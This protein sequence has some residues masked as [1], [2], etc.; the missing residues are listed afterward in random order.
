[1]TPMRTHVSLLALAILGSAAGYGHEGPLLP[2]T[3]P[4]GKYLVLVC[5]LNAQNTAAECS[6][7][8]PV[9]KLPCPPH[10]IGEQSS[11]CPLPPE[12]IRQTITFKQVAPP[13]S[14]TSTQPSYPLSVG[15]DFYVSATASSGLP[16]SITPIAGAV[17]IVP[18]APSAI[19]WPPGTSEYRVNGPGTVILKAE[20]NGAAGYDAAQPV[21]L[22]FGVGPSSSDATCNGLF[23]SGSAQAVAQ[24]NASAVVGL[25]GSPVPFELVAPDTRTILVYTTR[26]P[27]K[28]EEK[29]I[30]D[31][32]PQQINL[33]LSRSAQTLGLAA[34]PFNVELKIP[35]AAALGDPGSRISALNYSALTVQDESRDTVRITATAQPDCT[36]WT[37]FLTD[38][39][40]LAW[41]MS[42]ES[43]V[44]R[45]FYTAQIGASA[46][47][48][49]FGGTA[50]PASGS[51]ASTATAG[52]GSSASGG[53]SG[54]GTTGSTTP[55]ASG[56]SAASGSTGSSTSGSGGSASSSTATIAINQPPGSM[57]EVR[58]DTTPCVIAGLTLSNSSACATAPASSAG[59]SASS[60]STATASTSGPGTPA[61]PPVIAPL[62]SDLALFS[63]ANPGDDEPITEKKR[64]IAQLDLPR[65]EM[66]INAWV[67]QNS[68]TS[69][70]AI[71][72]FSGAIRDLVGQHNDS[73]DIM[74]LQAWRKVR[75]NIAKG[76]YFDEPFYHYVVDR[77]VGD[78][79]TEDASGTT[80]GPPSAQSAA[81][82]FLTTGTGKL[83]LP[84]GY[85]R[86]DFGICP[87]KQYCLGYATM[88]QPMKPRI[89]DTLLALIA[90]KDTL[91]AAEQAIDAAEG[92]P[93][94]TYIANRGFCENLS[95]D[96]RDH[97][98]KIWNELDLEK[99]DRSCESDACTWSASVGRPNSS[100]ARVRPTVPLFLRPARD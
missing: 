14:P 70:E 76:N 61:P 74:Q 11:E 68:T 30:L 52:T 80:G 59:T 94:Y 22:F 39:K 2:D 18:P 77:Y 7:P 36:T 53:T 62:G 58:S 8:A 57:V 98:T 35:H 25:I 79:G 65:P 31:G 48:A 99:T 20:Q 19:P 60:G 34:T 43:P 45:L 44:S 92:S 66:I 28:E 40:H 32:L 86:T 81:Q 3:R 84:S 9:P 37:N 90:A 93:A 67:M 23:P 1:V 50:P 83:A 89:T 71:G 15:G 16:V 88:F 12:L 73:L 6:P 10:G 4:F 95:R 78:A 51:S 29:K 17:A 96:Q 69:A 41:E 85:Q 46:V 27:P 55:S 63:S 13:G 87:D 21:S 5:I 100:C 72:A 42:P 97:C 54:T 75:E 38:V 47:T 64:I 49:A 33:L 26:N 24:L 82:K 56:T 91:G